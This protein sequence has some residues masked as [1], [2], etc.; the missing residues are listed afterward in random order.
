M[1]RVLLILALCVLLPALISAARPMSRPFRLQGKVYCDTCRAGFE[2]SATT[3]IPR[4]FIH[5]LHHLF[6]C[7][8]AKHLQKYVCLW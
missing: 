8:S 5:L 4:T 1:A 6:V 2:T 7:Y 3:Y